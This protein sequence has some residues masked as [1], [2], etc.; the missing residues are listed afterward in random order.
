M[1]L[2]HGGLSRLP[3]SSAAG[4]KC[5]RT[6]PLWKQAGRSR[7]QGL[8]LLHKSVICTLSHSLQKNKNLNTSVYSIFISNSQKHL[9][10][11]QTSFSGGTVKE[12]E[13]P[14][15]QIRFTNKNEIMDTTTWVDLQTLIAK[16][17]N[18]ERIHTQCQNC[19][20]RDLISGSQR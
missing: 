5:K 15:P 12:T 14:T 3:H 8:Q 2:C 4:Q 6:Q 20:D 11:T 10:T 13:P 16:R 19:R 7:Q 18:S 1:L 9:E 17:A